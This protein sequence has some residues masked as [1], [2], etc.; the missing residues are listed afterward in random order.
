MPHNIRE[1]LDTLGFE[2]S[3]AIKNRLAGERNNVQNDLH[4]WNRDQI[5]LFV[6]G[7]NLTQFQDFILHEQVC[8]HCRAIYTAQRELQIRI[9]REKTSVCVGLK[10]RERTDFI[11]RQLL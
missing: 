5:K 7:Q 10:G 9:E 11:E 8:P 3:P 4:P 2:E 6:Q 1:I